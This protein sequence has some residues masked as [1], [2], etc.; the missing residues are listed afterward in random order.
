MQITVSPVASNQPPVAGDDAYSTPQDTVLN[1]AG[2]GILV[3]DSDPEGH[4]L[5]ITVLTQPVHGNLSV[6]PDGGF[7]YTPDSGFTGTDGFTYLVNDGDLDSQPAS[8]QIEVE[9]RIVEPPVP[10][11]TTNRF[12]LIV[13]TLLILAGGLYGRRRRA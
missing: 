8:V 7:S 13:M 11:P 2:P 5:S 4:A 3:N 12:G 6:A 9:P 10:V 1:V